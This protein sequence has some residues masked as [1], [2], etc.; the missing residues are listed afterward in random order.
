MTKKTIHIGC[1]AGFSGDR[2][3][4][5]IAV[6]AD[7]KNRTGPCYLIFET[8]AERTLAA[9]QR[10]RQS[11]PDAGHAPN[12]L[13][14]LRPVLADCKVAGI[15]IISNF[16]AA[17]P[18]GASGSPGYRRAGA[19]PHCAAHLSQPVAGPRSL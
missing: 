16:G 1:G 10:Q 14:F 18:R 11:D 3:D 4:A 8:L 9:A 13:K 19:F 15:R 5:A 2:V 17:N 12:L 6:V 7:L